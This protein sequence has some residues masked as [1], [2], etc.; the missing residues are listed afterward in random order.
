[1]TTDLN[2]NPE[3]DDDDAAFLA[4]IRRT[5]DDYP[6]QH[7]PPRRI[8]PGRRRP[9]VPLV[10]AAAAA[11]VTGVIGGGAVLLQSDE[12]GEQTATS[13]DRE[14]DVPDEGRTSQ[15][16]RELL[17]V[18]DVVRAWSRQTVVDCAAYTPRSAREVVIVARFTA[19]CLRKVPFGSSVIFSSVEAEPLGGT[20]WGAASEP[21]I[22]LNGVAV[23]RKVRGEEFTI[24][25]TFVQGIWTEDPQ[26]YAVYVGEEAA[27]AFEA[28]T[29]GVSRTPDGGSE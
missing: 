8:A 5:Y 24:S 11:V 17:L 2:E 18:P 6:A 12:P 7:T 23:L 29:P 22:D 3:L 26:E 20:D 21:W 13:T 19:D 27:V 25:S 1:M 16:L 10:A 14:T 15:G 9:P 28:L 4:R